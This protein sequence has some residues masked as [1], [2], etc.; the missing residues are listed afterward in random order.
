MRKVDLLLVTVAVA[1]ISWA[2]A[3]AATASNGATTAHFAASYGPPQI[4]CSGER[5]G[6]T[7]P[8]AFL[9]DSETCIAW[10]DFYAPGTYDLAAPSFGGWCS[11]YEGFSDSPYCR[12][13]IAGTLTVSANRDG[14]STWRITAYYAP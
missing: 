12:L 6:K 13:A 2:V 11:D 5:V 14:S 7:G 8:K 3:T 4:T 1:A 9:K 10:T